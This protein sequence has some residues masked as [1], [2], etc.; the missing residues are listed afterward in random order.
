[1]VTQV[2][3]LGVAKLGIASHVTVTLVAF[4]CVLPAG[5]WLIQDMWLL[6]SHGCGELYGR[7]FAAR[8]LLCGHKNNAVARSRSV[9]GSRSC[10]LEHRNVVDV[11]GVYLGE[12]LLVAH[13]AVYHHQRCVA[14]ERAYAANVDV[15]EQGVGVAASFLHGEVW[16][17]TLH[18]IGQRARLL[19]CYL[20]MLNLVN[21]SREGETACCA[22]ANDHHLIEAVGNLV[23]A[24]KEQLL[25][26]PYV[27]GGVVI[28]NVRHLK[29]G[30][31]RGCKG[32][33]SVMVC[34]G[35]VLYCLVVDGGSHDGLSAVVD[36]TSGHDKG[37]VAVCCR[38]FLFCFV[39]RTMSVENYEALFYRE[40][41]VLGQDVA[42]HLLYWCAAES[43][44]YMLRLV[45]GIGFVYERHACLALNLMYDI[46]QRLVLEPLCDVLRP[47]HAERAAQQG[48]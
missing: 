7:P 31:G 11:V 8:A 32:E 23:Q 1:M 4:L 26:V 38:R 42:Q 43:G 3:N 14:V 45:Y 2:F 36:H 44:C 47:C 37:V 21:G 30:V 9:Y 24:N 12:R 19:T 39:C 35:A 25:A 28:A 18:G 27:Y 16:R 17:Q 6:P 48:R 13:H 40:G 10:V 34:H 22:I 20:V 46:T 5:K 41:N 15:G 33:P 29:R